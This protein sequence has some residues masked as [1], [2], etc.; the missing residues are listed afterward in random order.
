M[1]ENRIAYWANKRGFKHKH[2]A[3]E[4][5][6]STVTFSSWVHNKTQPDL[7]QSVKLS[8]IFGI[9]IDELAHG[10]KKEEEN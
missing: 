6:V 9:T 3:K 2:L 10:E 8:R 1:F 4:I 5:G 7:E